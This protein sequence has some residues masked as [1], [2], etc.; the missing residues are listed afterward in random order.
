MFTRKWPV[1]FV[2]PIL[3]ALLLRVN[4]QYA[5]FVSPI[6]YY[7]LLHIVPCV[8]IRG[9]QALW[10]WFDRTPYTYFGTKGGSDLFVLLLGWSGFVFVVMNMMAMDSAHLNGGVRAVLFSRANL[11][12]VGWMSLLL[13]AIV[14]GY[15]A[16]K[17]NETMRDYLKHHVPYPPKRY[18]FDTKWDETAIHWAFK[19]FDRFRR[20]GLSEEHALARMADVFTTAKIIEVPH[21]VEVPGGPNWD[22]P[23]KTETHY[24]IH[25]DPGDL[26]H[27]LRFAG[28]LATL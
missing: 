1:E 10:W 16:D 28:R 11:I 14:A 26:K 5:G 22:D 6:H 17:R 15:K 20:A 19:L 9:I 13:V 2:Y 3:V 27:Q 8:L 21:Q 18:S 23:C 25:P 4:W 7:I 24:W 12:T